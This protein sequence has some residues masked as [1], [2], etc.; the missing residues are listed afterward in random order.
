MTLSD[1]LEDVEPVP[2]LHREIEMSPAW[3]KLTLARR[4][5]PSASVALSPKPDPD[6]GVAAVRERFAA[7]HEWIAHAITQAEVDAE[8]DTEIKA[9]LA[10]EPDLLDREHPE[11]V[12]ATAL[13]VEL[14]S[15]DRGYKSPEQ[16]AL[17]FVL[18]HWVER[19][20]L[21]FALQALH[22]A[23]RWTTYKGLRAYT[24]P[25]DAS[26]DG[27]YRS[28]FR[29]LRRYIAGANDH[30]Y[31]VA[32]LAASTIRKVDDIAAAQMAFF[33]PTELD[34]VDYA[35]ETNYRVRPSLLQLSLVTRPDQ[36][37]ALLAP[38][39]SGAPDMAFVNPM[40]TLIEGLGE[41]LIPFLRAWLNIEVEPGRPAARPTD[42]PT[43]KAICA[44]LRVL[45]GDGGIEA[46]ATRADHNHSF[47]NLTKAAMTE[48]HAA[49][50]TLVRFAHF[51]E[52][53]QLLGQLVRAHPGAAAAVTA[54]M[55]TT[56]FA[57]LETA[58]ANG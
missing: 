15:R 8:I 46:L 19:G 53:Q 56:D 7:D 5:Y 1:L 42:A 24:G 45:G 11:A 3:R 51:S 23:T 29:R 49:I 2:E 25:F 31:A 41:Q 16:D 13:R 33:F 34:W 10:Q 17:P 18:D 28:M 55:S 44:A 9:R 43:C 26:I 54:T 22:T 48:P 37:H 39:H 38:S 52:V 4:G 14:F 57:T 21:D 35:I 36:M 40:P 58:V 27:W 50:R 6:R 20:G 32:R 12:V 47:D 30:D